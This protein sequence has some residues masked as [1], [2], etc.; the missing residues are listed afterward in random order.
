MNLATYLA[1]VSK[2][3]LRAV[4]A[5]A[6][7]GAAFGAAF[8]AAVPA[9]AKVSLSFTVAQQSRQETADYAYDGYYALRAAELVS[10][11]VISWFSTPSV[12]RDIHAEAGLGLSDEEALAAAGRAFRARRY[13]GQNVVLTFSAADADEARALADAAAKIASA[14]AD[15]LA[16]TS[17]GETLFR[18]S[19]SAPVIAAVKA[20]PRAA[21][22]AGLS[23]S[24]FLGYALAYVA[25]G[26]KNPQP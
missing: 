7:V 12:I 13:S 9:R 5:F 1:F 18:V 19:A 3:P 2:R 4:I 22:A 6:A 8:A 24:A 11:T 26:R 14:K 15:A 23:V 17:K 10:D 21:T 25:R 16:L 20:D